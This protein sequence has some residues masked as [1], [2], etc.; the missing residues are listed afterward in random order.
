MFSKLSKKIGD[1]FIVSF[2]YRNQRIFKF[3]LTFNRVLTYWQTS[4]ALN[5]FFPIQPETNEGSASFE[6]SPAELRR[7]RIQRSSL[8]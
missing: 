4:L 7:R 3:R 5:R 6:S 8:L 2:D 1:Y